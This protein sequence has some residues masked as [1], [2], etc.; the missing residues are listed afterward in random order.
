MISL[1]FY[2]IYDIGREIDLGWLEHS[3]AENYFAARTSFLR[4]KPKSIM[5]EAPPLTIRM[6]P[7]QV[8]RGG[9]HFAFTVIA[10][11]YEIGV[12]SLCFVYENSGAGYD[13][14][15]ET[16]LLFADQEGLSDYFVQY[17][18]TLGEIIRPHI[19]NFAVN[20]DFYEDY[21]IYITSQ[22]EDSIDPVPLLVGERI[23]LSPHI[24]EEIL[25]NTL[26]YTKDDLAVLS[27][28]S[29][30]LCNPEMP[31]DLIELIEYANVQ[32]LE[33]R[34]YDRELT[35]QMEKMYEDIEHADQLSQF[36][37]SRQYHVIMARQ[38]ESYAE[39]SEIIEKVDNLIKVTEDVYYARVY[40]TALKVLRSHQWS[41]S[42]SRKIDV[43]RENYSMLSDEVRIQ[44]SNFLEW[45]IIILIALEFVFAI[46]ESIH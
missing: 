5:I 13:T 46:W 41:E 15:E 39:I 45:I 36:R 19:R 12:I 22:R 30:L 38:M 28:D 18:K 24:R 4:V 6:L 7:V 33:L 32:V 14:L 35:R 42:V 40:A 3:L 34:Y 16:G 23:D 43:M 2:R 9:R 26:S 21:T 31:T 10:R 25:K 44:H 20:P 37:R 1:R 17:L 8:E 29:A 11:M 27:W